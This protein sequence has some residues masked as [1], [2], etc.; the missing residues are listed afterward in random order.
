MPQI[1]FTTDSLQGAIPQGTAIDLNGD[2][3]VLVGE[4]NAGKSS[5]LQLLFKRSGQQD[6]RYSL[7]QACLILPDRMYVDVNTQMGGRT[8]GQHNDELARS[9]GGNNR[10]YQQP[11][12][13]PMSSELPKLLLN[14][15]DFL[16]QA[17]K[18]RDFFTFFGL[19]SFD[20]RGAQEVIFKNINVIFQGSGLRSIFAILAALT[21]DNLKLLL[22]DE[23]EQSLEPRLQKLLRELFYQE[24]SKKQII[25]ASHSQLFLN[26][27][28]ISSNYVVSRENDSFGLSRVTSEEQL[29]EITFEKLGCSVEDLFFPNNFLIVEGATDQIIVEKVM[30]LKGIDMSKI[31]VVSASG[32]DKV[33]NILSAVY[34]SLL[35]LVIKKSPYKDRVVVLIDKPYEAS[36]TTY[37]KIKNSLTNADQ[38][39][40]ELDSPSLEA[41]LHEDLYQKCGLDKD[42]VIR[43][44]EREKEYEKKFLLKTANARAIASAL[45]RDDVPYLGIIVNAVKKANT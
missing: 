3:I 2:Y 6:V 20:I 45:T 1:S 42:E 21:D 25:V 41:Y 38:Q 31:K 17:G 14:H 43:E 23:P 32:V 15:T 24:S 34:T 10:S 36:N 9:I 5:L 27:Q 39:L 33:P 7:D 18:L 8:I 12:G 29:Y 28:D 37:T 22:I 44:I 40:F 26:R 19:P 30:E 16:N 11:N 4:N 35:P 13:S